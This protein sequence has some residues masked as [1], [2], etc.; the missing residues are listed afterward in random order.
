MNL[1]DIRIVLVRPHYGGNV[2]SVCRAMANMGL[3]DL[4]LADPGRLDMDE[5]RMMAC[6]AQDILKERTEYASMDEA[7][8]DCRTV[9][10]TTARRGLYRSHARTPRESAEAILQKTETGKTALVFG[11]EDNGLDNR[12]MGMCDYIVQIPTT[13]NY[14]SLNMAQAVMV[15]C[16]ELFVAADGFT[17]PEEKSPAA[18]AAF[19]ERMYGL[20]RDMLME[21][22]FMKED[23]AD[24]MMYGVRRIF[25]RGAIT[26]D[27]VRILMGI[28]RQAAWASEENSPQKAQKGT[29]NGKEEEKSF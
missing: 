5:A 26:T 14:R 6:H 3:S 11:P 25:S 7:A 8:A 24:H 29:K 19:K 22:G 12:E 27:D 20:W 10:G 15:C 18:S 21:T 28:A 9:A 17:P 16:Y 2:G 1:S 13:E 4:A 23:K